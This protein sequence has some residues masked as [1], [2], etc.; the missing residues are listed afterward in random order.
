MVLILHFDQAVFF[1][2]KRAREKLNAE[3]EEK[4]QALK[5][6]PSHSSAV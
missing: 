6:W 5:V 2:P 1:F 4:R 3:L